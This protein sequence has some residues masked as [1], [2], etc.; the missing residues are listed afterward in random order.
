[1]NNTIGHK[2]TMGENNT[3]NITLVLR[4]YNEQYFKIQG[5]IIKRIML[6][7]QFLIK[8]LMKKHIVKENYNKIYLA[9]QLTW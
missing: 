2:S 3:R 5:A 4:R 6:D 9:R 7:F 8:S 1:M